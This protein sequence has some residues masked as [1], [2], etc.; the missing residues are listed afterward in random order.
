MAQQLL[1]CLKIQLHLVFSVAWKIRTIV[2]GRGRG[3]VWHIKGTGKRPEH[4]WDRGKRSSAVGQAEL[5]EVQAMGG[6]FLSVQWEDFGC[7]E[8]Q[9]IWLN[10]LKYLFGCWVK[11][12][13]RLGPG[14]RGQWVKRL[15]DSHRTL[16]V[17]E[18]GNKAWREGTKKMKVDFCFFLGQHLQHLEVPRLGVEV[19][20]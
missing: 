7:K 14:W 13:L 5:E 2:P 10:F 3:N 19:E 17:R 20:L 6:S 12:R 9:I 15:K 11:N 4:G 18:D 16:Q 8:S 1:C